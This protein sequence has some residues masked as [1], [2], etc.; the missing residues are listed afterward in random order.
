MTLNDAQGAK[1]GTWVVS[2]ALT[3]SLGA[4]PFTHAGKNFEVSL[5]RA[6]VYHAFTV[7]LNQF[8]HEKYPGTN[9]PAASP[10]MSPWRTAASP[11][12]TS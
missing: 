7:K 2:A 9:T 8:T 11:C 5:R 1:L 3:E 12:A 6:R 10:A 4:Q